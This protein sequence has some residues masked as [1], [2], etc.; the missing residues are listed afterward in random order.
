MLWWEITISPPARFDS[1][2]LAGHVCQIEKSY[3]QKKKPLTIFHVISSLAR[4]IK[5]V[6]PVEQVLI[7]LNFRHT[8][9]GV[10]RS[11]DIQFRKV[12]T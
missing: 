9:E 11:R 1:D 8:V 10:I 2:Y 5:T 7:L 6:N 3:W 4:Q 12:T